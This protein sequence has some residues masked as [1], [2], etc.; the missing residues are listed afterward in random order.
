MFHFIPRNDDVK[1]DQTDTPPI[2]D[3][4]N[5]MAVSMNLIPSNDSTISFIFSPR[6]GRATPLERIKN[7]AARRVKK[8][9]AGQGGEKGCFIFFS[10]PAL[11]PV[12]EGTIADGKS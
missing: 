3:S 2:I 6:K 5:R 9:T 7:G 12:G 8:Q 11:F 10:R 1:I 4:T